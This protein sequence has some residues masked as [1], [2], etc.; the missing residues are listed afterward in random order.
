MHR[1]CASSSNAFLVLCWAN[2]HYLTT[3]VYAYK[4]A[5][6]RYDTGDKFGYVQAV[7][8]FALCNED[9]GPKVRDYLKTIPDM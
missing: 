3:K 1:F 6:K 2:Y 4:F 7:I 5:G 8:D 9:F